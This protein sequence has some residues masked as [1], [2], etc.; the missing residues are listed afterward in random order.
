MFLL[1]SIELIFLLKVHRTKKGFGGY[2][3]LKASQS[4]SDVLYDYFY[5]KNECYHVCKQAQLK[6]TF[7]FNNHQI[8]YGNPLIS[9]V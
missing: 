8:E 4:A 3:A 5:Y 1:L 6:H 2:L 7:V 9:H